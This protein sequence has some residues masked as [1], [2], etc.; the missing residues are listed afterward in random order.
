MEVQISLRDD[1][2]SFGY[3]PRS[4]IARAY[5]SS[6]LNFL[7]TLHALFHRGGTSYISTISSLFSTS[8]PVFIISC[9]FDIDIPSCI[10]LWFWFAFASPWWL[11]TLST[12]TCL[13]WPSVYL[14]W[15]N[16]YPSLLPT[17]KLSL[18]SFFLLSCMNF[19][20]FGYWSSIEYVVWRYFL[21]FHRLPF[22]LVAGFLCCTEDFSLM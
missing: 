16:V 20:Y 19:I 4:E 21:P 22:H 9:L 13:C 5:G 11:V 18:F 14:L 10:S 8:S 12:F 6:V 7:R 15:K 1:F 2:I 3:I 17:F